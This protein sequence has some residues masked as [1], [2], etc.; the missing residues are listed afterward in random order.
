MLFLS[1]QT[2]FL[3]PLNASKHLGIAKDLSKVDVEHVTRFLD[4]D[5]IIMTITYTQDIGCHTV[6]STGACE[7][8]HCLQRNDEYTVGSF[9]TPQFAT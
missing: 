1:F 4:H 5:I 8:V 7:V 6:A 9:I 2:T 3:S